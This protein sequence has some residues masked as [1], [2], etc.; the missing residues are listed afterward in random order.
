[1]TTHYRNKYYRY[2]IF[3]D[4]Y[5]CK[6]KVMCL[7]FYEFHKNNIYNIQKRCYS[8]KVPATQ[9]SPTRKG[10][11]KGSSSTPRFGTSY[12]KFG[13]P[14]G[15][16]ERY[17]E[18]LQDEQK[19]EE[20]KK[21]STDLQYHISSKDFVNQQG[22]D[23]MTDE[24]RQRFSR[25]PDQPS[26]RKYVITAFINLPNNITEQELT[27]SVRKNITVAMNQTF[28][29]YPH[30]Y[31][32]KYVFHIN[33]KLIYDPKNMKVMRRD[34]KRFILNK[35]NPDVR[36]GLIELE[37]IIKSHKTVFHEASTAITP[38]IEQQLL[39]KLGDCYDGYLAGK[40]NF[41]FSPLSLLPSLT[42]EN[43]SWYEYHIKHT[44][45]LIAQN[46]VKRPSKSIVSVK[47]LKKEDIPNNYRPLKDKKEY[48]RYLY[49]NIKRDELL[50]RFNLTCIHRGNPFYDPSENIIKEK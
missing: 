45:D 17:Y 10:S 1:M 14:P 48:N 9:P 30:D 12:I 23:I 16:D 40:V 38:T 33:C 19:L 22:L 26:D 15:L 44:C 6:R 35:I 7:N 47:F 42:Q 18:H 24:I 39:R 31:Y 3:G 25:N 36:L 5:F 2:K 4:I 8:D 29:K 34:N 49:I 46:A 50:S 37:K 20:D 41:E 13:K 21:I 28:I 43:F 32:N 11:K 27:E